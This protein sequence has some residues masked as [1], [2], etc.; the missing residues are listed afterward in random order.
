MTHHDQHHADAGLGSPGGEPALGADFR[1]RLL[2]GLGMAALAAAFVFTGP[3]PFAL[4]VV[5]VA[6][7]L[8]WEW[9]RLVHG[10]W[11]FRRTRRIAM[12]DR[13]W[14]GLLPTLIRGLF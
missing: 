7:L 5:V 11:S 2:S 10:S 12:R 6:M 13:L 9:S 3:M 4:L 14:S 8:S 1:L